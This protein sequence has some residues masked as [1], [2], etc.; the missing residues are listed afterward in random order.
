MQHPAVNPII[1]FA[2]DN[3]LMG[4]STITI[5]VWTSELGLL[6]CAILFGITFGIGGTSWVEG[7]VVL[8][9]SELSSLGTGYSLVVCGGGWIIG[10]PISGKYWCSTM[11]TGEK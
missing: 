9:G 3:L 6:L 5:G 1:F 2:I 4:I 11:S 8:L 10:V 7:I